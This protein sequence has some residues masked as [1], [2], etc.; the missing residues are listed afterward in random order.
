MLV[1][2][3]VDD[4][5]VVLLGHGC[6]WDRHQRHSVAGKGPHRAATHAESNAT[7][8]GEAVG[9]ACARCRLARSRRS[10]DGSA[11]SRST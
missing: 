6:S 8:A 10:L 3:E 9:P 1:E 5:T 11:P 2:K 4:V 7:Q